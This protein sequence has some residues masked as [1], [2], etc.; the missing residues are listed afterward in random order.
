M[1]G[2]HKTYF[3]IVK[4]EW[5]K[6]SAPNTTLKPAPGGQEFLPVV[7]GLTTN[8]WHVVC[9]MQKASLCEPQTTFIY[10]FCYYS[11]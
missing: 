10:A 4:F 3:M 1:P 7:H 11:D 5:T 8:I 9:A 2:I 6:Q